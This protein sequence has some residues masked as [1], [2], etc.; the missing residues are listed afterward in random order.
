MS[1]PKK[2]KSLN[3][4]KSDSPSRLMEEKVNGWIF[5]LKDI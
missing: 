2:N 1:N 5:D 3:I 4:K